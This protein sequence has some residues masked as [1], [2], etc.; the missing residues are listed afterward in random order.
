MV[1]WS[2]LPLDIVAHIIG[3]LGWLDQIRMRGVCKA[4]SVSMIDKFKF[5]LA[6]RIQYFF[7]T[8]QLIYPPLQEQKVVEFDLPKEFPNFCDATVH[9]SSYGWLL[10]GAKFRNFFLYSPF[11]NEVINLPDFDLVKELDV[12]T[13]SLDA[14]SPK[15]VIFGLRIKGKTIS[16][17]ICSPGDVAWKTY[18][19]S[20]DL[21]TDVEHAAYAG[22]IFYCVFSGGELGAFN[23]QL[24]EWNMLTLEGP[25]DFDFEDLAWDFD[26]EDSKLIASDGELRL[27]GKDYSDLNLFKFDF[28]EKCWIREISLNNRVLFIGCT[29]FSCPAVGQISQ[30][31]NHVLSCCEFHPNVRR[32]GIGNKSYSRQYQNWTRAASYLH[33]WIEILSRAIWSANDLMTAR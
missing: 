31:A 20:F 4:W 12:A 28:S 13:F 2:N 8:Y 5:P 14:T 30:L 11:T 23:L 25:A 27:I 22:G 1:D 10:F 9:A 6:I 17:Y 7:R 26:F 18:E 29:S 24:K 16:I 21:D 33:I 15:C 19:F 3:R 32:Y